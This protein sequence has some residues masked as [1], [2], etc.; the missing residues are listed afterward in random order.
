MG[1]QTME[2]SE[3]RVRPFLVIGNPKLRKFPVT[4]ETLLAGS[5]QKNFPE[6]LKSLLCEKIIGLVSQCCIRRPV[7]FCPIE[8]LVNECYLR[9]W[10]YRHTYDYR[11]AKVSTWVT[12]VCRSVLSLLRK[13]SVRHNGVVTLISEDEESRDSL[14]DPMDDGI[15]SDVAVSIEDAVKE[16][17]EKAKGDEFATKVV[18]RM[19]TEKRL[20]VSPE[21]IARDLANVSPTK[22]K[23]QMTRVEKMAIE[24]NIVKIDEVVKSIVSPVMSAHC[25]YEE[26]VNE[27]GMPLIA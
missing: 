7:P 13:K 24:D 21:E 2:E 17:R 11:R 1:G 27:R 18:S 25:S 9:I 12:W 3:K 22:K 23:P 4:N 16:I 6:N 8:D 19:F 26:V 15:K 10:S 5:V 14:L 20:F